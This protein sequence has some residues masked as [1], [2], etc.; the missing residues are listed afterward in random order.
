M[1][2]TLPSISPGDLAGLI[3]TAAAPIVLDIRSTADAVD[4]LILGAIHR[5]QDDIEHLWKALPAKRPVVVYDS[6]GSQTSWMV[7]D[8]LR[9]LGAD[10]RYLTDGFASW[11]D[12]GLPT[13]RHVDTPLDKWV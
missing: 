4:R 7:V 3:G 11:Q 8:G 1:S 13:R 9:R 5:P 10:A 2:G 12:R 6:S